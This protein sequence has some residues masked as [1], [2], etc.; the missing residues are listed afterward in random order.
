[1]N[2]KISALIINFLIFFNFP[3]IKDDETFGIATLSFGS[4]GNK[5]IV[6]VNDVSKDKLKFYLKSG[7]E[8]TEISDNSLSVGEITSSN[9]IDSTSALYYVKKVCIK[10]IINYFI[11]FYIFFIICIRINYF[12]LKTF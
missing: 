7:D 11:N 5:T 4:A 12:N 3:L 9:W 1:M 6:N 8:L 10:A 2:A